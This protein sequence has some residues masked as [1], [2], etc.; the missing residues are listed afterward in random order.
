M[1]LFLKHLVFS[2]DMISSRQVASMY[3]DF[4]K[5]MECTKTEFG[6]II[7]VAEEYIPTDNYFR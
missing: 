5:D 1:T 3:S 7:F 2:G 4:I 6:L